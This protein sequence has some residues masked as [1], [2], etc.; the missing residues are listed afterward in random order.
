MVTTPK[1]LRRANRVHP[2]MQIRRYS[3][4]MPASLVI[5]W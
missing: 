3:G 5:F 2:D 1:A 4:L